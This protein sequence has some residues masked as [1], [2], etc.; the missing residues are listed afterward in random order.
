[1]F[2]YLLK[3]KKGKESLYKID[4]VFLKLKKE[5][6]MFTNFDSH[7]TIRNYKFYYGKFSR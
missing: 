1:M 3:E 4:L 5:K 7:I 6:Q 2:F